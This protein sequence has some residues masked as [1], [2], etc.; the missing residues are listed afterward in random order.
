MGHKPFEE[1]A[2][3]RFVSRAARLLSLHFQQ[4][5]MLV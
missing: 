2:P 5:T 4:L 3:E 1:S